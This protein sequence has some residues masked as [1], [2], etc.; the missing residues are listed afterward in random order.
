SDVVDGDGDTELAELIERL[1]QA[2]EALEREMLG[3]LD[4][5]PFRLQLAV[6]ENLLERLAAE[7]R[8]VDR[9]RQ[10]VDEERALRRQADG[11]PDRRPPADAVEL[12]HQV[13]FLGQREEHQRLLE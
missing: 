8:I 2:L 13:G 6:A 3:D 11:V 5:Q 1:A 9:A 4:D 7:L 10:G 12:E